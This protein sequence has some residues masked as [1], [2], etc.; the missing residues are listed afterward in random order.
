MF[1]SRKVD[2]LF[3]TKRDNNSWQIIDIF[4]VIGVIFAFSIAFWFI[5]NFTGPTSTSNNSASQ[6]QS[7]QSQQQQQQNQQQHSIRNKTNN[8]D[9]KIVRC[10]TTKGSIRIDVHPNWAKRGAKRFLEMV[11]GGFFENLLFYRVPDPDSNALMQIGYSWKPE[12]RN[13]NTIPD[14]PHLPSHA[15][16]KRGEMYVYICLFMPF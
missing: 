12:L 13:W 5:Y 7:K 15:L 3:E 9:V 10:D 4:K 16:M 11:N 1:K 6:Q 14:D 2:S 8:E